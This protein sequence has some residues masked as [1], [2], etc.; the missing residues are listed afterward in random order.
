MKPLSDSSRSAFLLGLTGAL[1]V[2]GLAGGCAATPTR[3]R[4][5]R[6]VDDATITTQVKN[7]I[8][9]DE[10][11]K[12]L[13]IKVETVKCV[14]ELS[15]LVDTSAQKAAAEKDAWAVRG[16]ETVQNLLIVK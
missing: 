15:G 3:D 10:T 7:S 2:C 5:S 8:L 12:S 6:Y 1:V 4:A 16:V 13:G 14:V 9:A 11:V